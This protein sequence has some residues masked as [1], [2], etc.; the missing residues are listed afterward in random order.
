[1]KKQ[2]K[3]YTTEEKVVILSRH[4]LKKGSHLEA[5]AMKRDSS[6]VIKLHVSPPMGSYHAVLHF[7]R[8]LKFSQQTR[9]RLRCVIP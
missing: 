8:S 3:H 1:M 2:R 5:L 6:R 4:S 7:S 9:G